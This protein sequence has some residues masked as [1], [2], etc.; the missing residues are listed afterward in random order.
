MTGIVPVLPP[1]YSAR[2]F[3]SS[4]TTCG[5]VYLAARNELWCCATMAFIVLLTSLNYWRHP[6]H[7]WRRTV[8]MSAVFV[9]MTYH[10]YCSAFCENRMYQVFYL[11]FVAKTAYCYMK[12]RNA[13]NKN[14]SSAWHCGVHVVGNIAN[15]L[16][17]MGLTV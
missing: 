16:L 11:L 17:Y 13:S 9:G 2:L 14:E 8:D 10:I 12:A 3:R 5:S 7:G 4:F 6:V 15:M 1:K